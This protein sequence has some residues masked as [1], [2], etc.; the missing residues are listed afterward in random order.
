MNKLKAAI[1]GSGFVAQKR[2]IPSFLRLNRYASLCALCDLNQGL[3][4]GVAEKFGIKH[5]YSNVS[6]MLSRED[7]DIVDICTP[8]NSHATVAIEALEQGCNV[9]MEKPMALNVS[10]CS[11][12]ISSARAHCRKLSIVHN[13]RFYPP[14]IKAQELVGEGAIGRMIAMRVLALTNKQEYMVH[15]NHWV[16]K[17]PGGVISEV[18]PH[19]TYMSLAFMKDIEGVDVSAKKTLD[20]PWVRYDDYKIVLK[21]AHVDSSIFVSHAGD[22][23]ASEVDLFGTESVIRMDLE[24]MLLVQSK[25][26][27]LKPTS[28]ALYSLGIAGQMV[29]SVAS[30]AC[31][32]IFNKPMLGHQIMIEKYVDSVMNDK[33]VPVP[34][35]EGLE[36]T[37]VMKLILE[38]LGTG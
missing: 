5:V 32:L 12:M 33:P 23:W 14:F 27:E 34:P 38:K 37:R 2:H 25:L 17:L 19:T 11:K 22:Y 1:V 31:R 20:Y 26:E 24:S 8:P 29:K 30:N 16:H 36:T 15:E 9:L 6:E 4:A 13:Q 10:D 35:E 18:G 28:V 7:L 3:A 21:G